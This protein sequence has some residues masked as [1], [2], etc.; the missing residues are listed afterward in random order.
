M[1]IEQLLASQIS[2]ETFNILLQDKQ[3]LQQEVDSL[4]EEKTEISF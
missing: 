3:D 2:I 1:E 4:V